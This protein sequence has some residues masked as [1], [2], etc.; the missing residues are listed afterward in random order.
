MTY[1][2][3]RSFPVAEEFKDAILKEYKVLASRLHE[4]RGTIHALEPRRIELAKLIKV[5]GLEKEIEEFEK[6]DENSQEGLTLTERV[7]RA[8]NKY[9]MDNNNH[10]TRLSD[11]Y[12]YLAENGITVG[13]KNP[14]ST[15][16]AHLAKAEHFENDRN[17][18]WRIKPD[19]LG[20]QK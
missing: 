9:F 5:Y 14:N 18:G 13:G 12:V 19:T 7:I 2:W 3:T 17:R 11:L 10:W 6:Q 1:H 20:F 4:A 15:L 8:S 16:S